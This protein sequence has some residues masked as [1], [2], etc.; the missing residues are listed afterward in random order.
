M[1]TK[2]HEFYEGAAL[3]MMVRAGTDVMLSFDAPF[4]L[5]NK[6][7]RLYLKYS[8]RVRS[9]WGFTFTAEEQVLLHNVEYGPETVIGLICGSDG[10]AALS[11]VDYRG[12]AQPSRSAIH[13]ACYRLHGEHYEICGPDGVLPRKVPPSAWRKIIDDRAYT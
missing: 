7:A 11:C 12:I 8:T 9:P 10:V 3:H 1:G 6:S 13:V 4:F 2:K 5:L